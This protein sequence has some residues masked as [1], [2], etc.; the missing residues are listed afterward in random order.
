MTFCSLCW[1]QI[2][3]YLHHFWQWYYCSVSIIIMIYSHQEH[4]HTH[5]T[6]LFP[7]LPR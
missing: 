1:W 2:I 4:T 7:G 3:C 6:A 5:L